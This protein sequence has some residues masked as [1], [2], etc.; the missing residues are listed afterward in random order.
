MRSAKF[1]RIVKWFALPMVVLLMAVSFV[2]NCQAQTLQAVK[3]R[4][5]LRCGV[6]Q[7]LVGFSAPD[8]KGNWSGFDVDFCRAVA[9]AIFN[10]PNKVKY[11]ALAASERFPALQAGK[12]DLLSRNSTWTMSR[13][14][15]LRLSFAA[16]TYYDGQGF[17][18][19]KAR[20]ANSALELDGTKICVQSGTTTELNLAD[21][22]DA[23][24]MKYEAVKF[25]NPIDMVK[26]YD[27]QQCDAVTT[28]LSGL[29]AERVR[30]SK[31]DEHTILADIISKE[32]LG[33]AVRQRDVQWFNMVKWTH[34]AMLNAEELGVSS[35]TIGE[36]LKSSKPDV[37]RLVGTEGNYGQQIGLSKDWA[38]RIVGLV[39]NY[40]EVF[41]RNVGTGTKL[42]IPR[43]INHLWNKGGIQYAPPIR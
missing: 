23:N 11:I 2:E 13:E 7:G 38:V 17:L 43:G 22:F 6:G 42:G 29:Y 33:P 16:I 30:L 4:G 18:V 1:I 21:Y 37:K 39:G 10:N 24:G 32:P 14:A 40:G 9:A 26:A 41:D 20:K 35:K 28:D 27:A 8:E 15:E 31:P 19:R 34:F 5:V 25:S 36:A 3:K 12:I